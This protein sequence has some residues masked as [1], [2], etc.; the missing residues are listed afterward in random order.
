MPVPNVPI[1]QS[2]RSPIIAARILV[3]VKGRL[4]QVHIDYAGRTAQLRYHLSFDNL[5]TGVR[6][7]RLSFEGLRVRPRRLGFRDSG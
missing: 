4:F 2:L 6:V 7:R 1:V 3:S 5:S